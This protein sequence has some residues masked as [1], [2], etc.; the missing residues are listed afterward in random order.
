MAKDI[1][2][3]TASR[4]KSFFRASRESK[5]N[6]GVKRDDTRSKNV[7]TRAPLRF[8]MSATMRIYAQENGEGARACYQRSIARGR[9]K[10]LGGVA[11]VVNGVRGGE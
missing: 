3:V 7:A 8:M 1:T 11:W 2:E 4:H 5:L 10:A 6:S 9:D